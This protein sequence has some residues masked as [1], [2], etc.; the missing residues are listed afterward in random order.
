MV[1]SDFN[2][3]RSHA[4]DLKNTELKVIYEADWSTDVT[5]IKIERLYDMLPLYY[6]ALTLMDKELKT[7]FTA[8]AD[9][10]IGWDGV[11]NSKAMLLH[12]IACKLKP[13]ST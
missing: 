3:C 5:K 6:A 1:A 4:K 7:F 9:E 2:L 13:L 8:Y 11:I 10:E 12:I